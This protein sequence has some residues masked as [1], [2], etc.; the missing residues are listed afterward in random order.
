MP[1]RGVSNY[2]KLARVFL[3]QPLEQFTRSA[4]RLGPESFAQQCCHRHERIGTATPARGLLLRLAGRTNFTALPC[5]AKPREELLQC[6]AGR[7]R[8]FAI[9]RA[10]GKSNQLL[11]KPTECTDSR[12][13][14]QVP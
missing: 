5:R 14:Q 2:G 6:R 7:R 11:L 4:P 13:R 10:I 9:R 1:T 12:G 8:R 3:L